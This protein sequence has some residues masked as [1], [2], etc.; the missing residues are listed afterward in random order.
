MLEYPTYIYI[1]WSNA[2]DILHYGDLL[3]ESHIYVRNF[4]HINQWQNKKTLINPI[5]KPWL[6]LVHKKH[7]NMH[8][9]SINKIFIKWILQ[10]DMLQFKPIIGITIQI[11]DI[12]L[13]YCP[14]SCSSSWLTQNVWP[15]LNSGWKHW[16][17][18]KQQNVTNPGQNNT[19][20]LLNNWHLYSLMKPNVHSNFLKLIRNKSNW[21]E[22]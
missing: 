16:K 20:A 13:L 9:Y 8:S 15:I 1:W 6:F 22:L 17:C 21:G 10:A 2:D 18:E 11:I 7:Q 5:V 12:L 19:S 3:I 14:Y 4:A